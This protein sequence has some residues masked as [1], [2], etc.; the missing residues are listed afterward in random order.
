MVRELNAEDLFSWNNGKQSV[1]HD[2]VRSIGLFNL[3]RELQAQLL[4][5]YYTNAASKGDKDRFKMLVFQELSH[6]I[7][8]FPFSVYQHFTSG[9]AYQFNMDWLEKYAE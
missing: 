1:N 4:E 2:L 9:Q 7:Q 5:A 3:S 8:N 6:N